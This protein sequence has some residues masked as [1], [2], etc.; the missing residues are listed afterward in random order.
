MLYKL[1]LFLALDNNVFLVDQF[2]D[3]SK[4]R[5][6]TEAQDRLANNSQYRPIIVEYK[7]VSANIV[8]TAAAQ[9]PACK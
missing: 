5:L 3:E 6:I 4:E 1:L 2:V 7:Q 9:K 8:T